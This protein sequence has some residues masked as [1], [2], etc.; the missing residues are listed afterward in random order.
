MAKITTYNNFKQ[1]II[2]GAKYTIFTETILNG[3]IIAG[4]NDG[5]VYRLASDGSEIWG[6]QLN[7]GYAPITSIIIDSLQN[8]I[9]SFSIDYGIIV[10]DINGNN[11]GGYL[12]A[13]A[14]EINC[15]A[16][17]SDGKILVGHN[18]GILRLNTDYS[19]DGSF[20]SFGFTSNVTSILGLDNDEI[21]TGSA[22]DGGNSLIKWDKDVTYPQTSGTIT[23]TINCL[24]LQP[25][26][27]ILVGIATGVYRFNTDGSADAG[28]ITVDYGNCEIV[29]IKDSEVW[30]GSGSITILDIMDGS[31]IEEIPISYCY[32]I[33]LQ[34]DNKILV[35]KSDGIERYNT[36]YSLDT[37][38]SST[39]T[40]E[41]HA[42]ALIN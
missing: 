9:V 22:Y 36:D 11:L 42:I 18:T 33:S 2:N 39:I 15:L 1:K 32:Y 13:S 41:V 6:H 40:S 29:L 28:W 4:T 5:Y 37:S 23:Q 31:F 17:Q 26:G 30:Y 3:D 34:L 16:L 8:I 12:G 14:Y 27:K 38:F 19:V 24:A 10:L 7:G 25:D 35:G 21:W 20:N